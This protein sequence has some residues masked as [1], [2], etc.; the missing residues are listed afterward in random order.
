[1]TR[2]AVIT[3]LDLG[4]DS[5]ERS[6][7]EPLGFQVARFE[8]RTEDDVIACAQGADALMVQW[9]PVTDRVLANLP[10]CQII[11]RYGIG[12][13]MID[14]D[15]AARHGVA[16]HNVPDYCIEEVATHSVAMFL[17]L[18]R[19]IVALD[20][21]VVGGGWAARQVGAP[22]RLSE[23][24][25]GVVGLGRIGARVASS[26]VGLG[27][28]R[29]IGFDPV[30]ES[31]TVESVA[32]DRLLAEADAVLLHCPLNP[33]TRH[34]IGHDTLARMRPGALIVNVSRG[35]LIDEDALA[36]ALVSGSIGGAALDVFSAEPLAATAALRAAPNVIATPHAAWYSDHALPELQLL[37]ARN[38][39][40]HFYPEDSQ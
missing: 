3:D 5:L 20:R 30:S 40:R 34:M 9:A 17:A 8:C 4:A 2:L 29:V 35:G 10:S 33:S 7:L 18:N 24:T 23:M 16:V 19:Q 12:V 36:D 21:Q 28:G 26:L 14:V 31:A 6:I 38:V 22:R 27:C 25:V 39:A 11:S 15:A 32:L 13:D 1:V 37:A